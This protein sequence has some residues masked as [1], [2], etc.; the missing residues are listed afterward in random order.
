MEGN[1]RDAV[2]VLWL[3]DYD[4]QFRRFADEARQGVLGHLRGTIGA[5]A[6]FGGDN[7]PLTV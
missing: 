7:L 6:D 5:C 3:G 1:L 4:P 2:Y